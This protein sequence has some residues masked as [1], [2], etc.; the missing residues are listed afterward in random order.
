MSGSREPKGH[1]RLRAVHRVANPGSM[2]KVLGLVMAAGMVSACDSG[3][4]IVE[5]PPY[6]VVATFT[7]TTTYDGC[8]A[9]PL[10]AI[11]LR[12]D[13]TAEV[14]TDVGVTETAWADL[15]TWWLFPDLDV[16]LWQGQR[17]ELNPLQLDVT[18]DLHAPLNWHSQNGPRCTGQLVLVAQP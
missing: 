7:A 9:P 1:S 11:E 8:T 18:G 6:V 4:P 5:R 17:W 10:L 12:S 14:T 15:G 13:G 3:A 16:D 2:L